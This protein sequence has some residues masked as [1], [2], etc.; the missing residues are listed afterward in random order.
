MFSILLYADVIVL[1][2]N[3][4]GDLQKMMDTLV[5]WAYKWRMEVS[6][7][8]SNPVV[9]NEYR[10][11]VR[12]WRIG[13]NIAMEKDAEALKEKLMCELALR[14]HQKKSTRL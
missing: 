14:H 9:F 2:A 6:I 8:K 3:N 7:P 11:E 5:L 10:Q 13:A 4:Q 1:I 12:T